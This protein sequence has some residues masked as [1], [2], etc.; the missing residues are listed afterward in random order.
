MGELFGAINPLG[1]SFLV[2]TLTQYFKLWFK[3]S[4]L[5]ALG[6]SLAISAFLTMPYV[7]LTYV[8]AIT[9]MSVYESI[10]YT[11]YAWLLANGLYA[12]GK[13]VVVATADR[14]SQ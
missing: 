13:T 14:L 11:L 3:L 12:V 9:A 2:T 4:D 10:Y 1:I 6:L 8:G 7:L 5:P